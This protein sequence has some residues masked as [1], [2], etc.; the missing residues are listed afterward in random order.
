MYD[1]CSLRFMH[2]GLGTLVAYV[3]HVLLLLN[4]LCLFIYMLI[5]VQ[6]M[7]ENASYVATHYS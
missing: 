1:E 6:G 3:Q 7:D 4:S 2:V 5:I